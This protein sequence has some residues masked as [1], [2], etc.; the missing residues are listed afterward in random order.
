MN[1]LE[2]A[3][4][5]ANLALLLGGFPTRPNA[6]VLHDRKIMKFIY[7]LALL[8][9][10][11]AAQAT[12]LPTISVEQ[13]A[14]DRRAQKVENVKTTVNQDGTTTVG[15]LL[16]YADGQQENCTFVMVAEPA[17]QNGVKGLKVDPKSR[18]CTSASKTN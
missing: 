16:T 17:E 11:G 4:R 3:T 10:T 6:Q 18:A 7:V 12:E 8:C 15:A 13:F 14:G 1:K 2:R 9:A 5:R